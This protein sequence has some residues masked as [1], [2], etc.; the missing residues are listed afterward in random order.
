[1]NPTSLTQ[2]SIT[3]PE[4]AWLAL[5]VPLWITVATI[6]LF[7]LLLRGKLR[8]ALHTYLVG[9][10]AKNHSDLLPTALLW[11]PPIA[12]EG[13]LLIF[14]LAAALLVLIALHMVIPLF[15]ALLL[16]GPATAL[17]L[18]LLLW[19]REQQYKTALDRAL[20]AAVGR[21]GTQLRSGSGI[22]P[23]LE[24]VVADLPDGPLKAEWSYIIEHFGAPLPG[25]SLATPQQVVAALAA[26]TPS[27]RQAALLGHM[28]VALG[29]THDVLIKRVQAAYTALHAAEQRRSSAATE[30]AQMRYSGIAIGLAGVGMASY[31]A[32]T[33]WKRFTLAYQGPIGLIA[34]IIV[35]S[36]LLMPFVGGFL[37]SR[38]DDVD[39]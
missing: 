4:T 30:L 17:L 36:V 11:T 35:G 1:M 19:L 18:W 10:A 9:R 37:L 16:A 34:G 15:I 32:L 12:T 26:Q 24:K 20:P 31:L 22:Q 28:E 38:T 2:A 39:Y 6:L 21:L 8:A 23:A 29:Q 13:Q 14:C 5:S 7:S 27:P 3:H 33:Q 25:G